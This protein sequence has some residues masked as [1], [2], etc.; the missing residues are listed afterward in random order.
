MVNIRNFTG[1]KESVDRQGFAL[2]VIGWLWLGAVLL[3]GGGP[4]AH[5]AQWQ[6]IGRGLASPRWRS[7]GGRSGSR[8]GGGEDRPRLQCFRYSWT[9]PGHLPLARDH[10]GPYR[11]QRQFIYPQRPA[12]RPCHCDGQSHRP[13][14]QPT[15]A[16][17][18]NSRFCNDLLVHISRPLK[19]LQP[20]STA[21]SMGE[22]F[23]DLVIVAT[24]A[25]VQPSTSCQT[26][27]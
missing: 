2:V 6:A 27:T 16:G 11:V 21:C 9:A 25:S 7:S 23:A 12:L 5:P 19:L 4:D 3:R 24:C 20:T 10:S 14:W 18:Y 22:A 8:L 15:D 26:L 1:C 13:H 17:T